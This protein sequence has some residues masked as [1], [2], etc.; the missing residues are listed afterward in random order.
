LRFA[1]HVASLKAAGKAAEA[2]ELEKR[3]GMMDTSAGTLEK[4][5][6]AMQNGEQAFKE[7]RFDDAEKLYKEAVALAEKLP[8]GD[9]NLIVALGRLGNTYAMRQNYTDAEVAFH[10]QLTI[11]EKTFG[12]ESPRLADPLF[13]LGSVA[14]GMKNFTVA[15][16][17]FSRALAINV[18]AFGE[19]STRTAD[20]LR[21]LAG[22]YMAQSEW[23]K[24]EPYLLR[25]V[26]ASEAAVGPNDNMVLIPLWGLCDLY[27]RAGQPEKSQPCWHRATGIMETQ[28]G[29][30]SP[31]LATSL[32]NESSALRRLGRKDEADQLD[33]RLKMIHRTATN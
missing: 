31:N 24:A 25:A 26:K 29:A 2:A 30:N 16:S 10:R 15:E 1:E 3:V 28:F 17:Y 33:E 20:S 4:V 32:A 11:I 8:P 12:A 27:D 6:A 7:R 5:Q 18:K 22:L 13:Y 9:E 14:G 21:T 23:G 19:N